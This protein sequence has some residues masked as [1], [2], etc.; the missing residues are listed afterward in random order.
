V[1]SKLFQVL[2]RCPVFSVCLAALL[3]GAAGTA[4]GD[5]FRIL[6]VRESGLDPATGMPSG[7]MVV[8]AGYLDGVQEGQ[9]GTVWRKNKFAGQLVIADFEVIDV[10]PYEAY[11]IYIVRHPDFYPLKKDRVTLETQPRS[12][13]DILAR[14]ITSL[15]MGLCFDALLYFDTIYCANLDNG[16]IMSQVAECRTRV[17]KRLSAEPEGRGAESK[18]MNMYEELEVAEGHYEYEN[19]LAADIH[20]KRVLTIEP[21]NSKAVELRKAIEEVDLA[22]IFSPARCK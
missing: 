13:A 21:T 11:G 22:D 20:L 16:F 10:S 17:E 12:E 6:L 4:L 7:R 2:Y 3:L 5:D 8:K 18:R 19:F 9:S 15:D 14:A 1:I